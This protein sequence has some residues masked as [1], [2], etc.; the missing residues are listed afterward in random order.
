MR[1]N[2]RYAWMAF[3]AVLVMSLMLGGSGNPPSG[4]WAP[5]GSLTAV[6]NGAAAVAL[7]DGR[8]LVIG[9][10]KANGQP[11]NTVDVYSGGAFSAGPAMAIA[12]KGHTATLLEDG[13]VLVA[14]G[15]TNGGA[16]TGAAEIF[17][18]ASN[19]WSPADPLNEAR[20]GAA[21]VSLR[22]GNVLVA[23]GSGL[24]GTLS[25]IEIYDAAAD[26][27]SVAGNMSTPRVNA[28]AATLARWPTESNQLIDR[29]VIIVGGSNGSSALASSD[30]YDPE[31]GDVSAG[32]ALPGPRQKA[33]AVTVLG[34]S[35]YVAGGNDGSSDLSSA[36]L[37][38]RNG[39]VSAAAA[40]L[41][42]RSG[43]IAIRLPGNNSVLI[44]GG[45]AGASAE[46]WVPWS[47]TQ[48]GTG[49]PA[50]A[51]VGGSSASAGQGVYLVAGGSSSSSAELYGYATVDTDKN[52]YFPGDP[53][54]VSGSGWQAGETVNLVL[55]EDV[56]PPFHGDITASAVADANGNISVSNFYTIEQHDVG[57]RFFLTAGGGSSGW[58]AR[59]TFTDAP[60]A[61]IDQC[62]TGAA[63]APSDCNT[64]AYNLG[65]GN[66]TGWV[67]G[68][69]GNSNAHYA[70]G[71]SI[72]YR[73][74]MEEV[75]Q[76]S[77]DVFLGYDTKHSD[78]VAIDFLTH[79]QCLEPHAG[80]GHAAETISP[81]DGTAHDGT[82]PSTFPIPAPNFS[83]APPG[84][85]PA[86][87]LDDCANGR[88]MSIWGGTI[89]QI[90]YDN[91]ASCPGVPA[92]LQGSF[93]DGVNQSSSVLRVR[94]TPSSTDVILGWGG[95]IASRTEWGFVDAPANT[96]PRSAGGIQG[97]P[98]H[99]RLESWCF[100]GTNDDVT[101][102]GNQDRSLSA[103]A[104]LT[105]A[106]K[107]GTKFNDLNANGVF[108]GGEPG[109][110]GW[111]IKI[112]V[113]V[114]NSN[115][116]N[117]NDF[118][119]PA[120]FPIT[121]TTDANGVYSLEVFQGEYI[122]C[123][124]LQPTWNQSF[125]SGNTICAFDP[126]LGDAGYAITLA[127]GQ[128]DLDNHFGNFQRTDIIVKKV[129]IGG[130]ATFNY[131]GNPSGSIST[132]NGMI[133]ESVAPGQYQSVEAVPPA[134]W[135]LYSISCDDNNS[136]G[137][138][139]TRT[140]TF[141]VE[142][143]EGP[144]TCTFTNIKPDAQI[145][146]SPLTDVNAVGQNHIITAT[147]Q[148]DD[149][150]A[151]GAAGGDNTTGFGPAPDGTL[152][153]FSLLNNAAGAVFVGG[154][155]T[156]MTTGGSCS[157]TI[158]SNS[159]GG[160]DIHATTTF[161]VLGV[162]LTRATGTGG[163]NSADAHKDYVN[164]R[165]LIEADDTNE[166]GTPHTFKVTV[167]QDTGSG[168]VGVSG[169]IVDVTVQPAPNGGLDESDCA[170][171]T[172]AM[173]MC[174]ATINSSVAGV[175]T[176]T[177]STTIMVNGVPFMI[178]T[179]G[180]APNSDGAV[181]TYVEA[182]IVLSPLT[183]TNNIGTAHTI[184]ATVMED[185][186]GGFDPSPGETVTFSLLNN[187]ANAFFV[188]GVNTCVTNGSGQCSIQINSNT[189]GSVDIHASV[190][191]HVGG[192]TL[193]RETDGTHGSSGDANKVYVSGNIIVIKECEPASD[194]QL[195]DF[196][197]PG[198]INN[199]SLACGGQVN[200]GPLAPGNYN[201]EETPVP[202]G[203][204]LTSVTCND[205]DGT[206]PR[207]NPTPL[208]L[209]ANETITCTYH[210]VKRGK[211]VLRKINLGRGPAFP[212]FGYFGDPTLP[213][214]MVGSI[215]I[216]N[217]SPVA[218]HANA[219]FSLQT[220]GVPDNTNQCLGIFNASQ[221]ATAECKGE[222]MVPNIL[223]GNQ[224]FFEQQPNSLTW[225]LI[226]L[227]CTSDDPNDTTQ[228]FINSTDGVVNG[229]PAKGGRVDMDLDPGE[230]I[231][232][233]FVNQFGGRI[234]VVKQTDPAGSAQ[235]FDFAANYLNPGPANFSLTDADVGDGND[236]DPNTAP[237]SPNNFSDWQPPSPDANHYMVTETVPSGWDLTDISCYVEEGP[238]AGQSVGVVDLGNNKVT[239]PLSGGQIV[240]C[241]FE[242]TNQGK[243]II[244]KDI[245][246][247]DVNGGPFPFDA[248]GFNDF[249]L[250]DDG[251]LNHVTGGANQDTFMIMLPAG[252]YA[253]N[254]LI[255]NVAPAG[256]WNIDPTNGIVCQVTGGGTSATITGA[257]I[258]PTNNFEDGD[259]QVNIT[260]GAGGQVEC[261]YTNR[262][263]GKIKIVKVTEPSPDP[264]NTM[265]E[266]DHDYVR[267]DPANFF[268]KNGEMNL[269]VWQPV[270]DI[271]LGSTYHVVE[272]NIPQGWDLT[273]L[274][275]DDSGQAPPGDGSN[276]S[277][278][279]L[280]TAT[281]TI[282]LDAGEI[283]TCTY[284]NTLSQFEGCT[285][286]FWKTHAGLG[287][288]PQ[289]NA[290]E[291]FA[292]TDQLDSVWTIPGCLTDPK[293]GTATLHDALSFKGGSGVNGAA[294]ILFRAAVA[295]L[296]NAASSDVNYPLSTADVISMVQ[297]A[298][299][300]CDR[301]TMLTLAG[302]LDEKNNLGCPIGGPTGIIVTTMG[303]TPAETPDT[304]GTINMGSLSSP[305]TSKPA[306]QLSSKPIAATDNPV[307]LGLGVIPAV[308]PPAASETVEKEVS[309]ITS[310][311]LANGQAEVNGTVV[312]GSGKPLTGVVGVTFA[313]Y[314][315]KNGG[316][317]L[318]LE[319]RNV[320]LDADGRYTLR[321]TLPAEL[322][323]L[324]SHWL[325]A[326]V[327]GQAEQ[328]RVMLR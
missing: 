97:S 268:L 180:Q 220:Q 134:G 233:T 19:S 30:I 103:A 72:G 140:A 15:T 65:G 173:G 165:I 74:R 270:T 123:E 243:I 14:G 246:F 160:V 302:D 281:A 16:A 22:D 230:T 252:N 132:N 156:C 63:P 229:T 18:P 262:L 58:E 27:W 104:V 198:A 50:S 145:D 318:W 42:P 107:S 232:C 46:L 179:D 119:Q 292:P 11:Q 163:L 249:N 76:Q 60:S 28:A 234:R 53:V 214:A 247:G 93:A 325:G 7:P 274:V 236:T 321:I 189:A 282:H 67:N 256:T 254:E 152:V 20:S 250:L 195:F 153:T 228:T 99:M 73:V 71:L 127:N 199:A 309:R 308:F 151:S 259:S 248:T 183:G 305:T 91:P 59:A 98:Y 288:G 166:V 311:K 54:N 208:V 69:A 295:A 159:P 279:D 167:E 239:V 148:Q 2:A 301:N 291:A 172:N 38:S 264:T 176:A 211:L 312:D 296:L 125:P 188:G 253:V 283:V 190:D 273:G 255:A 33:S 3:C 4:T 17:D 271:N 326:Q 29:Q 314:S 307:G 324:E 55:H 108:D 139:G 323:S 235:S 61:D 68:N 278:V 143:G 5:T 231:T 286:G 310:L 110:P 298:L 238:S 86:N 70:E 83:T 218:P 251:Q 10:A 32:P 47:N 84:T 92:S 258:N 51:H 23:G 146:L 115:T 237:P 206:N 26:S 177:A 56:N 79:Y 37:I 158:V 149:M 6:R 48:K 41:A 200:S 77:I 137:N 25:S 43:H 161:S 116:L 129:M 118:P 178:S 40:L 257:V 64:G 204:D 319:T 280:N 80:F 81:E 49:A 75:P 100:A 212:F 44:A 210:N 111:D 155:N 269:S 194:P 8:V 117:A 207:T 34:G 197:G 52:D 290:W 1:T 162:S 182:K 62:R 213:D 164:A 113:D 227:V 135:A 300:S 297:T 106:T 327:Q 36:L 215:G 39:A 244:H 304:S 31:T 89:T 144:I 267:G 102:L 114:D 126:T 313:L 168:F 317:P 130:T 95:H 171:G 285:P 205:D 193:H 138:V 266:Y 141:N 186:G 209:Q 12:R 78:H 170:D 201:V 272:I 85:T 294:Q 185:D 222:A 87:A 322:G 216:V 289:A 263:G 217:N 303:S 13:R 142:G 260:L 219:D 154:V 57:I 101:N 181:K 316:S 21:A 284:T 202:T 221:F 82:S 112:F 174:N 157:V 192:L 184:T 120:G 245:S 105:P 169:A 306:S 66:D 275:C 96:D 287:P 276:P 203:W 90:G 191:V 9:G 175:F 315:E 35:V 150:L 196:T 131:T 240:R 122:V 45:S 94:F 328:A 24:S 88:V 133:M 121:D 225:R 223:P 320:E 242:N 128:E 109:L 187:T 261:T 147:V 124:V 265:F 136:T 293:F 299:N 277:T 224:V 241:T 226:E